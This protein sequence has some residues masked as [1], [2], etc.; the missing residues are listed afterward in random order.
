MNTITLDEYIDSRKIDRKDLERRA[1]ALQMQVRAARLRELRDA[2]A[3][4]QE[5]LAESMHVSQRRISQ[6]ETGQIEN[7]RFD[8]LRRY[9]EALGGNLRVEAEFGDTAIRIA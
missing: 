1:D 6:I 5:E 8:T 3:L 2:Q 7:T 4:T 9:V